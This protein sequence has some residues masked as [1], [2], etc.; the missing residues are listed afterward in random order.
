[1]K[2]II[3]FLILLAPIFVVA[4]QRLTQ[5]NGATQQ[6][7]DPKRLTPGWHI[8]TTHHQVILFK[9]GRYDG[10]GKTITKYYMT[11][12]RKPISSTLIL[13]DSTY[14]AV[15]LEDVLDVKN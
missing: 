14:K 6:T 9:N 4:Q 7:I 2:Q 3:I 15:K 13:T 12:S 1:M 11:P 5:A 10:N 8:D